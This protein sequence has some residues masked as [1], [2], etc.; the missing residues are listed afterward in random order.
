VPSWDL[1]R[2]R[3]SHEHALRLHQ[4]GVLAL[5]RFLARLADKM[6]LDLNLNF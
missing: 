5:T 4:H 6:N 1:P 3:G 2:R